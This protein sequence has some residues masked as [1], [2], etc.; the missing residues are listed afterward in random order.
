[1]IV[2]LRGTSGSGK[3]TVVRRI[4]G[5]LGERERN[6]IDGRKQPISYTFQNGTRTLTVLGHYETPCGGTDTITK[7][8][9][10]YALIE[11]AVAKGHDVIYEGIMVSD[12][13]RRCIE[14]H[15]K[16][17]PILVI[18]LNTPIPI[19]I[20]GV[21]ARRDARND[22]RPLNTKNTEDR[23]RRHRSAI[24]KLKDAGLDARSLD[25]EAAFT[26]V[27]DALGVAHEAPEA[28]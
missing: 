7:T 6:F 26:A 18:G 3:S 21:Q 23:A 5:L 19:C 1:M 25:R 4:M 8:D 17:Y 2:N 15:R 9:D 27:A 14:L 13:T 10:V 28:V 11:E 16:G 12:D 20:A 24:S 22:L